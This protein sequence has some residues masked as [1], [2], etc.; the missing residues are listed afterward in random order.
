MCIRDSISAV[1][2]NTFDRWAD[3]QADWEQ[4]WRAFV[5]TQMPSASISIFSPIAQVLH[6]RHWF[7]GYT[8]ESEAQKKLSKRYRVGPY[9]SELFKA[10]GPYAEYIGLSPVQLQFL[11]DQFTGGALDRFLLP[12]E[13]KNV[14]RLIPWRPARDPSRAGQ[15]WIELTDRIT[16]A[17]HDAVREQEQGAGPG[18]SPEITYAY[19]E[20]QR[21]N[22][23]LTTLRS[24][25]P[26][27][28]DREEHHAMHRYVVGFQ[29][30]MMGRP[31]GEVWINPLATP[32]DQLPLP[33]REATAA[34]IAG[35]AAALGRPRKLFAKPEE[36]WDESARRLSAIR[37]LSFVPEVRRTIIQVFSRPVWNFGDRTVANPHYLQNDDTRREWATRALH[38]LNQ[39]DKLRD[40]VFS[41]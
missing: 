41:H 16:N 40:Y 31:H 21:A 32:L 23:Y 22:E 5:E 24:L 19:R 1:V 35:E 11:V 6:N 3:S 4:L 7:F 34:F 29:L 30:A 17:Y 37:M 15:D 28:A 36:R 27:T 12:L 26:V 20:L 2:E 25:V 9:T 38:N 33:V 18:P 39:R 14:E 10:L 8:I 13:G